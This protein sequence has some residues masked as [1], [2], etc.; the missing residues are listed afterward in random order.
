M[1]NINLQVIERGNGMSFQ[2]PLL[3][4]SNYEQ[5]YIEFQNYLP[6]RNKQS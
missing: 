2:F 5:E 1:N 6:L 4:F 3:F